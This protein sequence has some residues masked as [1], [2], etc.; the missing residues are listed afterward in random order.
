MLPE[1]ELVTEVP[2]Q[3]HM[4][5]QW[6]HSTMQGETD[7]HPLAQGWRHEIAGAAL[8]DLVAGRLA[9]AAHP[10]RPYLIEI[11]RDPADDAG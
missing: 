4:H 9:V 5:Y 2:T 10:R 3:T 11:P 8:A 1:S 7:G 6:G